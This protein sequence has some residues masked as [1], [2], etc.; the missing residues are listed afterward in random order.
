MTNPYL[1]EFVLPDYK[2]IKRGYVRDPEPH[3]PT[4]LMSEKELKEQLQFFKIA[5]ERFTVPEVLFSPSDIG[6]N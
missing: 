2:T 5:S 3:M 4:A 1:K 6:I